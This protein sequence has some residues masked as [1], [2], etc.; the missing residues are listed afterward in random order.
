MKKRI[1]SLL[2]ALVMLVGM[3]PATS[4]PVFA[5]KDQF[6][7]SVTGIEVIGDGYYIHPDTN[8]CHLGDIDVSMISGTSKIEPDY[9][10]ENS[11]YTNESCTTRLKTEPKLDET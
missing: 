8:N 7:R 4:L 2:L 9:I 11:L 10:S 1:L 6:V 5:A 3:I